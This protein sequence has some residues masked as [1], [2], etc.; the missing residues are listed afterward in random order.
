M[1]FAQRE[2]KHPT[3]SSSAVAWRRRDSAS[4]SSQTLWRLSRMRGRT[5]SGTEPRNQRRQL[6]DALSR[7]YVDQQIGPTLSSYNRRRSSELRER[8]ATVV[9]LGWNNS[10]TRVGVAELSA[11]RVAWARNAEAMSRL[12]NDSD[13]FLISNHWFSP[14]LK[15]IP[16]IHRL[17]GLSS[18]MFGD[19]R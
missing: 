2:D 15:S 11:G 13:I 10:R 8:W 18:V 5:W 17:P 19:L 6:R 16:F 7:C 12:G 14:T 4:T 1:K 3:S 9:E